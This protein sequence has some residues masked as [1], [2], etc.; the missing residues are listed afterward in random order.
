MSYN[1]SD[2]RDELDRISPSLELYDRMI[3]VAAIITRLMA[4]QVKESDMPII[5]GG[6]SL[7]I[8]TERKY[9]TQDIDFVTSASHLLEKNLLSLDFVNNERIFQH[10]RLNVAV[11]IVG[12]SLEPEDYE[13]ITKLE[14][15]NDKHVYVQSLESI[16]YDRVLDYERID[17]EQYSVI[18]IS[19]AYDEIDFEYL[20]HEVE[21]ADPDALTALNHWIKKA[22]NL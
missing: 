5:V 6:L 19:L 13:G 10:K 22:I 4:E 2:A 21:K 3:K 14:V 12:T 20:K 7:E 11:D 8:Y 1:I 16:L 9:T 17:N 15:S 18:L